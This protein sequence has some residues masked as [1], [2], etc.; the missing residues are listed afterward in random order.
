M[1]YLLLNSNLT[2]IKPKSP[3]SVL[4]PIPLLHQLL[5]AMGT[6]DISLWLV[7]TP[8]ALCHSVLG[9]LP[10]TALPLRAPEMDHPRGGNFYVKFSESSFKLSSHARPYWASEPTSPIQPSA[11][12][13]M[14]RSPGDQA[15]RPRPCMP[16]TPSDINHVTP[17]LCISHSPQSFPQQ[18]PRLQPPQAKTVPSVPKRPIPGV[19]GAQ[20]SEQ[21]S[22]P[23]R[24][25][26]IQDTMLL[27]KGSQ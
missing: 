8:R 23:Y 13:T 11:S 20:E 6:A 24:S 22:S 5:C 10:P 3:R 7:K 19:L 27:P 25:N 2:L 16:V 26:Q 1:T 18:E 14:P 9:S 17:I 4:G 12:P 21:E 15:K